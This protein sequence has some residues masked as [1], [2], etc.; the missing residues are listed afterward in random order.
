[1]SSL[2][3]QRELNAQLPKWAS[4]SSYLP[5]QRE[6]NSTRSSSTFAIHGIALECSTHTQDVVESLKSSKGTLLYFCTKWTRTIG[7]FPRGYD[8]FSFCQGAKKIIPL[9]G[10]DSKTVLKFSLPQKGRLY[11]SPAMKC[12]TSIVILVED[13]KMLCP[14]NGS[15]ESPDLI[16]NYSDISYQPKE[17]SWFVSRPQ[18]PERLFQN[19]S[20]ELNNFN[21]C[22][23][24]HN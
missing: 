3:V 17:P 2:T 4:H 13:W 15:S 7:N 9:Y 5:K 19:T 18:T 23:R 20:S 12:D 24:I 1:M 6:K 16:K 14:N 10:T 21:I 8:K 11:H 22:R